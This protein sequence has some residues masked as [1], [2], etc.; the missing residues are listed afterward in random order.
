MEIIYLTI[1]QYAD[2]LGVTRQ[3][4]YNMIKD[5]RVVTKRLGSQQLIQQFK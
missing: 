5:G 3:T 1:K 4:V 2:K